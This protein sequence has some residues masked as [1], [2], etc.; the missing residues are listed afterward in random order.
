MKK[1]GRYLLI[2]ILVLILWNT[3]VIYP[4]KIFA[5]YLHELGH[6]FMAIIFGSKVTDFK[7]NIDQSGHVITSVKGW[8]PG[9][10]V[11]SGGYL[12][13]VLFALAILYLGR[14]KL[15]KY[16]PG[17]LAIILLVV[18]IRYFSLSFTLIYSVIFAVAIILLYMLQ[19]ERINAWV[20]DILGI[21]S[22]AY[23][24][25]DTF[26]DTVLLQLSIH[27]NL[28]KGWNGAQPETDAVQLQ[29]M[30]GVPAIVW[31]II[32]LLIAL[33]VLYLALIKQGAGK[34]KKRR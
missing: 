27:F 25:Y 6:A 15:K 10:M 28:I 17:T 26:V 18:S 14:T 16:V 32:W 23:A 12:G 13:S 9:F 8:F 4:L 31:G 29:K 20:I 34:A 11:A 24:V 21:S 33:A 30:T 1:K 19:N 22:A 5:V 3:P 2:L 7:V